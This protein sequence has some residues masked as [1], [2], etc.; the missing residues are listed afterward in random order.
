MTALSESFSLTIICDVFSLP[1]LTS[2]LF[3]Q[4]GKPVLDTQRHHSTY[5]PL[6]LHPSHSTPYPT[7]LTPWTLYFQDG[8]QVVAHWDNTPLKGGYMSGFIPRNTPSP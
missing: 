8:P 7:S 1:I 6:T 2:L 3:S 5:L 4:I